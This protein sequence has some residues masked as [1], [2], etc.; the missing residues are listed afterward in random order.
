[1][2]KKKTNH[3]GTKAQ[4]KYKKKWEKSELDHSILRFFFFVSLCLCG[5]FFCFSS[6]EYYLTFSPTVFHKVSS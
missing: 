4:R 6:T 1:L 3:K 5:E 2:K